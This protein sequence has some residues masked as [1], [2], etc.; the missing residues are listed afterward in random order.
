MAKFKDVEC[1]TKKEVDTVVVSEMQKLT[2]DINQQMFLL[3]EMFVLHL[4]DHHII[5]YSNA[6]VKSVFDKHSADL[7]FKELWDSIWTPRNVLI[8]DA[9]KFIKDN[10]LK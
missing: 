3:T 1:T 8:T 9:D 5:D 6:N 2:G 7:K 10:D 4:A